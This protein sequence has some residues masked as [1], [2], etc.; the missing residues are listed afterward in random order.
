MCRDEIVSGMN[1]RSRR[2]ALGILKGQTQVELAR[3]ERI[4]QSA[5]SQNLQR[6]GAL[7]LLGTIEAL[8]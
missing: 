6:N 1:D 7:A 2:L 3:T 8:R 5:V 4:S